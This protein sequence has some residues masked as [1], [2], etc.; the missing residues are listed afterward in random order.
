MKRSLREST[1]YAV[2]IWL[3]DNPIAGKQW[4]TLGFNQ[5]RDACVYQWILP[6][7]H[8]ITTTDW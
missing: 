7:S 2:F 8:R 6:I 3:D 4:I 1:S 5:L